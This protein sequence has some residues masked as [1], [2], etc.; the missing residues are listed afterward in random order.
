MI[1]RVPLEELRNDSPVAQALKT[2]GS[3]G[4]EEGLP[5]RWMPLEPWQ[6]CCPSSFFPTNSDGQH[7]PRQS[8]RPRQ[9]D[10]STEEIAVGSE[11]QPQ[12]LPY[13]EG[14]Q[15]LKISH[16]RHAQMNGRCWRRHTIQARPGGHVFREG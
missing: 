1:L 14:F 4:G 9:I 12:T 15:T 13:Q 3:H 8:L 5:G 6:C 2:W 10:N 16:Q 7:W 11:Y